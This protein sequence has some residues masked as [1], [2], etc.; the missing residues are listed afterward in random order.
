MELFE[1]MVLGSCDEARCLYERA[2]GYQWSKLKSYRRRSIVALSSPTPP[3][4][5]AQVLYD[6]SQEPGPSSIMPRPDVRGKRR[7]SMISMG[8]YSNFVFNSF[9]ELIRAIVQQVT[10]TEMH[11]KLN[12]ITPTRRTAFTCMRLEHEYEMWYNKFK[13]GRVEKML[14]SLIVGLLMMLIISLWLS[15]RL[16]L[17][18]H[19]LMLL[20]SAVWLYVLPV[21]SPEMT[22]MIKCV[23]AA[24]AIMY[25]ISMCVS[26][27][28]ALRDHP[29]AYGLEM[30]GPV[31]FLV[32][33]MLGTQFKFSVKLFC[34][35]NVIHAIVTYLVITPWPTAA[36]IMNVLGG[37]TIYLL[38]AAHHFRSG[39]ALRLEFII[40]KKAFE[41]NEKAIDVLLLLLPLHGV[42]DIVEHVRC[43]SGDYDLNAGICKILNAASKLDPHDKAVCKSIMSVPADAYPVPFIGE[44]EAVVVNMDIVGFSWTCKYFS[45]DEACNVLHTLFTYCDE[46]VVLFGLHKLYTEGD[47]YLAC[48]GLPGTVT[49][50]AAVAAGVMLAFGMWMS[51]C[52]TNA[53]TV[54]NGLPALSIRVSV[55]KGK[56]IGGLI[57]TVKP[58]YLMFDVTPDGP[59]TVG[60]V[61]QKNGPSTGVILAK[62][63]VKPVKRW[64]HRLCQLT[65]KQAARLQYDDVGDIIHLLDIKELPLIVSTKA[66]HVNGSY[67]P[68]PVAHVMTP[69]RLTREFSQPQL[70]A[71]VF[72]SYGPSAIGGSCMCCNVDII[73]DSHEGGG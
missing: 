52:K 25:A 65:Q 40:T 45:S 50:D 4:P 12:N 36:Y 32:E 19:L 2:E 15:Q 28:H 8:A 57:G 3:S 33:A 54:K 63:C 48:A 44:S 42:K 9:K 5:G 55:A 22:Y 20:I 59:M 27:V 14:P 49:G 21:D 58:Q 66:Q 53:I 62:D 61:L 47:G 6:K 11:D 69:A 67:I 64:Q 38:S 26:Y 16:V 71:V 31:I 17:S 68:F 73:I 34:A 23:S 70:T 46:Y 72:H 37:V 13:R 18:I 39:V 30:V 10:I 41:F 7:G 51:L 60:E 43:G 29:R 1:G 56:C 35:Y 24:Q